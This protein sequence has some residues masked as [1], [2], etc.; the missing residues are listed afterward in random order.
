MRRKM[1]R[2]VRR[3]RDAGS[4][5]GVAM[6]RHLVMRG[7]RGRGISMM[8]RAAVMRHARMM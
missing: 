8:G 5:R 6:R 7:N 4:A 2:S 3:K 1:R